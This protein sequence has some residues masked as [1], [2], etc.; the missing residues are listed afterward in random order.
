[1]LWLYIHEIQ[2]IYAHRN[3]QGGTAYYITRCDYSLIRFN[4][5]MLAEMNKMAMTAMLLNVIILSGDSNSIC[6]Q[7]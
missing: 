3:E 4:F 2:V 5:H 6:S 7:K 1:M